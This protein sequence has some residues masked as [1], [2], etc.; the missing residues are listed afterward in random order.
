MKVCREG[1]DTYGFRTE[2]LER[3]ANNEPAKPL[4]NL[5]TYGTLMRGEE[6]F[7]ILQSRSPSCILVAHVW[8][9]IYNLGSCPGLDLK[10]DV[11]LVRGEFSKFP[12]TEFPLLLKKLDKT[13]GLA[14]F[15]RRIVNA[16]VGQNRQRLAWTYTMNERK[17]Q[18]IKSG[19]WRVET[20]RW[21]DFA[22]SILQR[23]EE[24]VDDFY[25]KLAW[26]LSPFE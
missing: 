11:G 2:N 25:N 15:G 10:T 14:G 22:L 24:G 18:L 21:R 6:R 23:H 16:D 5:F 17:G 4:S 26:S 8:G 13:E 9:Q 3:A 7:S 20:N 1:F 19:C 12:D